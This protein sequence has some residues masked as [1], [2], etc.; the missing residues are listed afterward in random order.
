MNQPSA[1]DLFDILKEC[2]N[3]GLFVATILDRYH[4]I[5]KTEPVSGGV[6]LDQFDE[7]FDQ[8]GCVETFNSFDIYPLGTVARLEGD[9]Q[10][11]ANKLSIVVYENEQLQA[12]VDRLKGVV[13]SL[14][15][16]KQYLQGYIE[17][18]TKKPEA[19]GCGKQVN[20]KPFTYVGCGEYNELC[21]DCQ[22]KV[23][24]NDQE[25]SRFEN[26]GCGEWF[27]IP[28]VRCGIGNLCQ[29]CREKRRTWAEVIGEE[30]DQ[31]VKRVQLPEVPDWNEIPPSQWA[32]KVDAIVRAIKA[33]LEG[34]NE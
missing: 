18:E 24:W 1:N 11:M 23:H 14:E 12:E 5:D 26:Y 25:Q 9:N 30:E 6:T 13:S 17:Q 2:E 4:L 21:P 8:Y 16:D 33:Q 10:E 27:G 31:P 7:F 19:V 28:V 15:I 29:R 32:I 20:V 3:N 34:R 22:A